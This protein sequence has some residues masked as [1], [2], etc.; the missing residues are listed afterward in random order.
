MMNFTNIYADGSDSRGTSVSYICPANV[1]FDKGNGQTI[2]MKIVVGEKLIEQEHVD[3][4]EEG[5][6]F[7]GWYLEEHKWDFDTDVVQDHMTLVA[8]Y[9]EKEGSIRNITNSD[10]N[11]LSASLDLTVEDIPLSNE[12]LDLLKDYD[13]TIKLAVA[14]EVSGGQSQDDIDLLTSKIEENVETAIT[15][16]N[17]ELT[18]TINEITTNIHE[19]LNPVEI[20]I[21]IPEDYRQDNREYTVL[22]VH[23]GKV[24]E[25]FNGRPGDGWTI[26]F[27]SDKFS[28]YSLSF[29]DTE[30]HKPVN[31]DNEFKIPNTGAGILLASGIEDIPQFQRR[32]NF[33]LIS[34][35]IIIS[36]ISIIIFTNIY[37][38]RNRLFK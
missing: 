12:D 5:Y 32:T 21:V 16:I 36:I 10:E 20:T 13:M 11:Y 4:E 37:N 25:M 3:R 33:T 34:L 28:I 7:D 14:K 30:I 31:P 18:K 22:R 2:E 23:D 19:T 29:K 35:L 24:D 9:K 15:F 38:K 17:I 6:I 26:T 27:T 8:K 1:V